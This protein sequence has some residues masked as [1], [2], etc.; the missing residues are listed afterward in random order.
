MG[1]EKDSAVRDMAEFA[2]WWVQAKWTKGSMGFYMPFPGYLP[3]FKRLGGTPLDVT[4]FV[5]TR[6]HAWRVTAWNRGNPYANGLLGL[7]RF[8]DTFDWWLTNGF[9]Q[10]LLG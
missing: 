3:P 9:E 8:H 7:P 2:E 4:D 6:Y 10:Q 1:E 5:T